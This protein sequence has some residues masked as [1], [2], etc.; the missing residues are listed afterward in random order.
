M[1]LEAC[2]GEAVKLSPGSVTTPCLADR[3]RSGR[4][5]G[6][7]LAGPVVSVARH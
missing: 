7:W 6:C 5:P 2:V 3:A 4:G 1:A